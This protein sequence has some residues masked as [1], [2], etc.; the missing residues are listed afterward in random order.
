M[1]RIA[2]TVIA[3][4]ESAGAAA[5]FESWLREGH[6]AEVVSAGAE[7]GYLVALENDGSGMHRFEVRYI[8]GSQ[9]LFDAYEAGP[10]AQLRAEGIV[11]F[12]P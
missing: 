7:S 12:G 5:A 8:F 9:S 11:L 4:T 10:A 2:Y 1:D 6:I 3:E